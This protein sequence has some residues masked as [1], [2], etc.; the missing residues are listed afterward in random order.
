MDNLDAVKFLIYLNRLPGLNSRNLYK[1]LEKFQNNFL[2]IIQYS[3]LELKKI[4][5]NEE[6]IKYIKNPNWDYVNKQI[7]VVKK[8]NFG[9]LSVFDKDYPDLLRQIYDPPLLLFY[10]GNSKILK[11]ELFAIVGTRKPTIYGLRVAEYFSTELLARG[12]IV[13]SGF[14]KGIDI[15]AHLAVVNQNQPT[16]VVLGTSLD[17]IY[18]DLHKQH[19]SRVLDS[20]GV[21]ISEAS[22][23]TPPLRSCFPKRNRII[24]GLCRGVLVVEA[25]RKSG[26]LITARC[27]M[28]QGR[29]VFAVPGN[30]N[31]PLALGC[32]D[33]IKE[34]VKLTIDIDDI[35]EEI[36]SFRSHKAKDRRESNQN[37][38]NKNMYQQ[39]ELFSNL[40]SK[41]QQ[42]YKAMVG[43]R[44]TLDSLV[45]NT[46]LEVHEVMIELLQL[47]LNGMISSVA[48]GYVIS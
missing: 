44:A 17:Y 35:L 7:A 14:A 29:E 24:S 45:K 47:E 26:S 1:L 8:N 5:F 30:I 11:S 38:K 40:N 25:A 16:V 41:Q 19:V 48:G 28:E 23:T 42:L 37:T 20:G 4:G 3:I 39:Q 21:I 13:T 43:G 9:I 33:L 34:G 2:D 6:Q 31:N 32:L 15:A 46:K 27:A 10:Q 12:M 18:P 36:S 22:F